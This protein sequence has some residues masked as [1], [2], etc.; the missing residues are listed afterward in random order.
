MGILRHGR[1]GA[2]PWARLLERRRRSQALK[3]DPPLPE[4]GMIIAA[5]SYASYGHFLEERAL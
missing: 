2:G 3:L 5:N 1:V 4:L